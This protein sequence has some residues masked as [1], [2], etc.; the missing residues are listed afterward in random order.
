MEATT[1]KNPQKMIVVMGPTAAGKSDLAISLARQFHGEVISAD[2]RQV[3]RGMDIGTGKI[4]RDLPEKSKAQ[5]TKTKQENEDF[6]LSEGIV[7]HLI[8]VADPKEDYNVSHFV[9]DAEQAITGIRERGHLP[10]ICGGTHFWIETLLM[11]SALP[12]VKPDPALR[13]KLGQ[14]SADELFAMLEEKDSER[15][16]SIDRHNKIRL[17]RALEI[18]ES[19]GSVPSLTKSYKP[20]AESYKIIALCPDKETLRKNIHTRLLKRLD[21]GMVE[22][23]ERLHAEGVSWQRLESFG[24]EY[25]YVALMLQDK[26]SREAMTEELETAIWHYAKRQLSFLRRL[27]RSG[28]PIR[29]IS[30][31]EEAATI[32]T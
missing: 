13:E 17:I 27:E 5:N 7:H 6:F 25:R 20:K 15:A 28:L 23:V 18:V 19:L 21:Q 12:A 1:D 26:L 32:I 29:W 2:S 16:R 4:P 9:R 30:T 22:E 3:Y 24:L 14:L 31:P 11:G 10:I 8:D